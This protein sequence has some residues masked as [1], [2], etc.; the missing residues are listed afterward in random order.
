MKNI[1]RKEE[2]V[3]PVIATILMVA[4]TVVLAATLYMMLPSGGGGD[5][6]LSASL[7]Y[8]SGRSNPSDGEAT[9]D[10]SMS[11]PD[12]ADLEDVKIT[13]LNADGDSEGS[14][15]GLESGDSWTELGDDYEVTVTHLSSGDDELSGGDRI[16]IS[17]E[18]GTNSDGISDW[19]VVL[20]ID[21]YDGSRSGVVG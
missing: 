15:K 3:S 14:K 11:D 4:I 8:N 9:F 17:P 2:G 18:D 5:S 13:L 10:L 21:G 16:R 1:K 20:S 19:E 6:P 7:S 12:T